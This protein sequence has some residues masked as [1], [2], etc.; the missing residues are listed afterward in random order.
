MLRSNDKCFP[1]PH[2][3]PKVTKCEKPKEMTGNAGT[4]QSYTDLGSQAIVTVSSCC[5]NNEDSYFERALQR[6]RDETGDLREFADL[7]SDLQEAIRRRAQW[8][9]DQLEREKRG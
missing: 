8:L 6:Y 4:K 1:L 2:C 7:E 9:R 3:F 5:M